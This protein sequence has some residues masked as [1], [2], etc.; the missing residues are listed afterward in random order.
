M[1]K[2]HLVEKTGIPKKAGK[3][4]IMKNDELKNTYL[5]VEIIEFS[6]QFKDPGKYALYGEANEKVYG[7]YKYDS[8]YG[9]CKINNILAWAKIE[10][11]MMDDDHIEDL[12][13]EVLSSPKAILDLYK[14]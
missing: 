10:D 14:K 8:E 5:S 11:E 12:K 3:Y 4:I 13:K 9:Y 7:F 1:L 2:W 6:N